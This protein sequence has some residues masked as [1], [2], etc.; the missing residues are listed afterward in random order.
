[1]SCGSVLSFSGLL[2]LYIEYVVFFYYWVLLFVFSQAHSKHD[3]VYEEYIQAQ[4]Q[5][6]QVSRDTC[7]QYN[8]RYCYIL[9]SSTWDKNSNWAFD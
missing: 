2:L 4:E 9:F 6:E 1:M 3:V 8:T 5:L 7:V